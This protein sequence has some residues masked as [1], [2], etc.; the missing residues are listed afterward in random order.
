MRFL[1]VVALGMTA[2]FPG[3]SLTVQAVSPPSPS[4]LRTT[5]G[6]LP[7]YFVENG[8]VYPEEV[9]FYVQG[10]DKTLFFTPAGITFRLK[11]QDRDWVVKLEFIGANRDVVPSGKDPQQAIFSYFKGPK[12][13]WKTGLRTFSRIVYRDLWP[14]ID[15][16]Y[17]AGVGV[18]KYEFQVAPGADPAQIRLRYRGASSVTTT[19]AGALRVETPAAVFEDEAPVAHQ[20]RDG[21]SVSVAFALVEADGGA[22]AADRVLAFRLGPYDGTSALVIDPVLLAY[23]GYIGGGGHWCGD[24]G[25]G[26]A[27]DSAGHA[28]VTGQTFVSEA[29]FPVAVGPDRTYNGASDAYVAKVDPHGT[30]LLYCGYLGGVSSDWGCGIA[31]D[32]AGNAFVTGVAGS[33]ENSFPVKNGPHLTH[34]GNVDAF[35]AKVNPQG[36]GLDYCGYIGGQSSDWGHGIAVDAFGA[37]YVVGETHSS[38]ATFPV[39]VGPDTTHNGGH[40]DGFVAKVTPDGTALVYCGY[41]GGAGADVAFRVA[42]DPSGHALLTGK[43]DSSEAT[44]P[45][46]VGPDLTHNG[47]DD[48]FVAKVTPDGTRLVFCGYVGGSGADSGNGIAVDATGNAYLAGTTSSNEWTFPVQVGPDLTYNGNGDAFVAKLDSRGTPLL[49]CG[50][51]GGSGPDSDQGLGVAIDAMGNA[52]VAGVACSDE[53]S[54]PVRVGPVLTYSGP[55]VMLN[56]GDGFLARVNS[57]GTALVYCGY[58]GGMWWDGCLDVAADPAGNAY[59]T[60]HTQS[61]ETTFPVVVGPD[62]T[63]NDAGPPE[64]DAFVARVVQ[65][66]LEGTGS[67]RPGGA[68]VLNLWASDDAGL[69]YQVGTSQGTGPIRID[70]RQIDLRGD[71]LLLLSVSGAAPGVFSGYRAVI[72]SQ[73]QAQAAIHIPDLPALIGTRLHTAFVTLDRQAPSGVKSISNT[74]S[75]SITT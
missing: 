60:G 64:G 19:R 21:R 18:L 49:Y 2:L 40:V 13:E 33:D 34:R 45:V 10:A 16:V 47:G 6:K 62:L 41:V 30:Q 73:G 39:R 15:L 1:L 75:F 26:I 50:Y 51:L 35:V 11:G 7:L 44:F 63:Y 55:W 61:N 65:T 43:T 3:G 20:A 57:Q 29:T 32:A 4:L 42:V 56:Y 14:G 67:P 53:R 54:F 38:E 9:K 27:V 72:D 70:T 46:R 5:F 74:F 48:A 52:Y 68:V 24:S 58:I 17:R 59:V 71:A 66:L 69:A 23:C 8:G 12:E 22:D 31:V 28:Y 36:T 25:T 37:A